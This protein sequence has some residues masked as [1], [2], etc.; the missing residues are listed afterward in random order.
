MFEL[1]LKIVPW[2]AAAALLGFCIAWLLR[3]VA[4]AEW[5]VRCEQ[6]EA[7]LGLREHDLGELRRELERV[8]ARQAPVDVAP[9]R[10]VSS[11]PR[12]PPEDLRP[13]GAADD[14]KRIRGVGP[15]LEKVLHRL[16]VHQFK[17]V[18]LWTETDIDFFDAQLQTFRG[19]IRRENWV[20]SAAEEHFKKHG[21][22]LAGAARA[23]T[24]S[25]TVHD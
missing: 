3:G 21:E 11:E 4:L 22:W 24:I 10:A 13:E 17:Q 18:A 2:L 16:G 1:A 25:E 14:L 15:V 9:P 5:H 8:R 6:L 7:D 20:R 23:I 12:P 19:R